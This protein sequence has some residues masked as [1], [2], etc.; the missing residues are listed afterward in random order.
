VRGWASISCDG[1]SPA[2]TLQKMQLGSGP[3]TAQG[4]R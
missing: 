1:I 3:A 4:Y 2:R